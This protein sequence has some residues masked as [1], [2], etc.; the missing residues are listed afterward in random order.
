MNGVPMTERMREAVI[1]DGVRTPVG[2]R[3][4]ALKN[5]HPTDLLAQT[6]QFG[7]VPRWQPTLA[8]EDC[9]PVLHYSSAVVHEGDEL[10]K[11]FTNYRAVR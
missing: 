1:I 7:A 11:V 9:I 8:E 2:R 3:G 4:G 10:I 6:L 5:W